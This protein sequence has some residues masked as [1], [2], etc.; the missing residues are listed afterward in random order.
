MYIFFIHVILSIFFLNL[1]IWYDIPGRKSVAAI[2]LLVTACNYSSRRA[3][4]P[5]DESSERYDADNTSSEY[6]P[7]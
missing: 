5:V 1:F 7:G 6:D 4:F 3:R 2:A